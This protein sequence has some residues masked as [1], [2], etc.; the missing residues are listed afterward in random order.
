FAEGM[1]LKDYTQSIMFL[2]FILAFLLGAFAATFADEAISPTAP[3]IA[4][5][6]PL[7]AETVILITIG[8]SGKDFVEGQ[9][10]LGTTLVSCLLLFAMGMQNS[11][12]TRISK[13]T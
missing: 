12:V 3:H 8:I 2:L 11:L 13:A 6:P 9:P 1:L 10:R 7:F 4:H 5:L